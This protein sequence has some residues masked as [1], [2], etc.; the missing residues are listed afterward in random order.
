MEDWDKMEEPG[1]TL[2]VSMPSVLDA[3]LCP[4]GTHLVHIFTPDW[5]DNWKVSIQPVPLIIIMLVSIV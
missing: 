5:I 4:D 2:F 1:G 3:S